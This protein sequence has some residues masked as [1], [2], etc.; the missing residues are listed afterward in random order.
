MLSSDPPPLALTPTIFAHCELSDGFEADRVNGVAN[1]DPPPTLLPAADAGGSNRSLRS[2]PDPGE[3][4][5]SRSM[6]IGEPELWFSDLNR[7]IKMRMV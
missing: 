4:G 6:S 5:E 7:E 1:A 2:L 3:N